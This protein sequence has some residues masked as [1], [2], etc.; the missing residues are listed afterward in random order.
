[1]AVWRYC[2]SSAAYVFGDRFGDPVIDRVVAGFK[3]AR[4]RGI[5]GD[6][7]QRPL[8]GPHAVRRDWPSPRLAEESGLGVCVSVPTGG[9]PKEVCTARVSSQG[10]WNAAVRKK[11]RKLTKLSHCRRPR[12]FLPLVR[13]LR[14]LLIPVTLRRRGKWGPSESATR[15]R[16]R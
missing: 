13:F 2:E 3:A 1:L 14:T 4:L 6:P 12:P 8:L 9:R 11:Q 15:D 10:L 7:G 5:D 16:A